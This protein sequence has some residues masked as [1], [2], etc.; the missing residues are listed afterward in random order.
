MDALSIGVIIFAVIVFV[1]GMFL[2]HY[3]NKV[4]EEIERE[5]RGKN[6]NAKK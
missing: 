1:L 3:G 6:T 4:S 2:N 5:M